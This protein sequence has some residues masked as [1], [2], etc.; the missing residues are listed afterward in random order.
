MVPESSKKPKASV[1]PPPPR[2]QLRRDALSLASEYR[3][4]TAAACAAARAAPGHPF[5]FQACKSV[6]GD[7]RVG[8]GPCIVY[9]YIDIYSI[10]YIIFILYYRIHV[11]IYIYIHTHYPLS[12]C[13][14]ALQ[15]QN[16]SVKKKIAC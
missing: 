9:I 6:W 15:V 2:F 3:G 4:R 11:F 7:Y 8:V 13:R 5:I 12:C 14:S 10:L 1:S 16:K